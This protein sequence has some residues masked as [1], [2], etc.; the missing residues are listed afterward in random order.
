[1]WRQ[2]DKY[3]VCKQ[4]RIANYSHQNVQHSG[5]LEHKVHGERVSAVQRVRPLSARTL[6]PGAGLHLPRQQHDHPHD[7]HYTPCHS[8]VR[9]SFIIVSIKK[10][11]MLGLGLLPP[12]IRR[13][14]RIHKKSC[15]PTNIHKAM[16]TD[17][18]RSP[19]YPFLVFLFYTSNHLKTLMK[20]Y[21]TFDYS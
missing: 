20:F 9:V 8:Y 19:L 5:E 2:N 17:K 21:L 1:M 14:N 7:H 11:S 6:L 12:T 3:D 13:N 15:S 4:T 16:R 10:I 18:Y